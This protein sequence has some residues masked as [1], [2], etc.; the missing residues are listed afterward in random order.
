MQAHTAVQAGPGLSDDGERPAGCWRVVQPTWG[1]G[2]GASSCSSKSS[3][4]SGTFNRIKWSKKIAREQSYKISRIWLLFDYYSI[5]NWSTI[6]IIIDPL[7]GSLF[8]PLFDSLF[9]PL[10]GSLF[11]PLFDPLLMPFSIQISNNWVKD[12]HLQDFSSICFFIGC[13][14]DRSHSPLLNLQLLDLF[15]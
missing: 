7:F 5:L 15:Y 8:D 13:L 11:D 2:L 3:V 1:S 4:N 12:I 9:D 14:F 10:F 6:Q